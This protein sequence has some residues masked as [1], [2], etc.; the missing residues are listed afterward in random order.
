MTFT[1]K[2][3]NTAGDAVSG[4]IEADSER[5]A[6]AKLRQRRLNILSL[7]EERRTF[8]KKIAGA[9]WQGRVRLADLS[10]FS[11][12]LSTL[13]NAGVPI[14]QS[15]ITLVEQTTRKKLQEV[16]ASVREEIER[17]ATISNALEKHPDVFSEFY[18]SMVRAGESGG[19]LDEILV[20]IADYLENLAQLRRKVITAMAYPGTVSVIATAVTIFIMLVIIPPFQEIYKTLGVELPIPTIIL[21]HVSDILRHHFLWVFA[22]L[23]LIAYFFVKFVRTERGRELFDHYSL[24]VPL[25][26]SLFRKIAIAKFSRTFSTMVRAGVPILE[27]M[28]VVAKTAGNKT[29]ETAVMNARNFIREGEKITDP[30]RDCGVFPPMVVQMIAIGEESGSLDIMLE[31]LADFYDQQVDA[32]VASLASMIEP[33]LILLMGA[34]IGSIIIAVFLPILL[35]PTVLG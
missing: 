27:A 17:G 23:V 30:L 26:G 35:M 20:R 16:I 12:Q 1:Y 21:L 24:K 25:F 6:I 11:R 5:M 22:V 28:E 3:K 9:G 14:I 13:V 2:A 15:L 34:I 32:A 4:T 18:I 7:A 8:L 31:K 10:L 19:V 33:I 29:V